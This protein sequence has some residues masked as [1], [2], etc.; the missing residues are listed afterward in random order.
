MLRTGWLLYAG[1]I[2]AIAVVT[3]IGFATHNEANIS[4]LPR[5]AAVFFP[6]VIA[7][8][9]LAPWLGLF[10]DEV[11]HNAQQLW[12]PALSALFAVPLAAVVR[13]FILNA[14][15]IPIFVLVLGATSALGMV[16]WRGIYFL[17]NRK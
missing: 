10:R 7:W 2:L 13:G 5:I 16:I 3:F 4:F 8:F 1:D 9:L 6:L 14:A 11:T 15:I 12:R 17:I